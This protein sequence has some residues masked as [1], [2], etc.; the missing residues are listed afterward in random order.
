MCDLHSKTI[1]LIEKAL[2]GVLTVAEASC[3]LSSLKKD[4]NRIVCDAAHAVVHFLSDADI[5]LNDKEY[6]LI[7]RT[8][9]EKYSKQLREK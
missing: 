5:R 7:L 6:D 1:S 8:E 4:T 9:L 2:N 3:F